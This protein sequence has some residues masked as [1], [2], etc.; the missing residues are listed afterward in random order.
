MISLIEVSVGKIGKSKRNPKTLQIPKPTSWTKTYC[1]QVTATF[2]IPHFFLAELSCLL[3]KKSQN[4][5]IF[6]YL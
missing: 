6:N 3:F 1:A 4:S 5:S 2:S